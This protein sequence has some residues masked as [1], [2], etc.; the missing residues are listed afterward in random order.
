[1]IFTVMT[2]ENMS[3][4]F[5]YWLLRFIKFQ[6]IKNID[7]R[8]VNYFNEL[9][10]E[11]KLFKKNNSRIK[12]NFDIRKAI[13]ISLNNLQV[14]KIKNVY[15]I[16]IPDNIMFPNYDVSISTACKLFNYGNSE[17]LGFPLYTK[18][19]NNI[20]NNIDNYYKLYLKQTLRR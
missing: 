10:N 15:I 19:F 4:R 3:N 17:I 7:N 14:H 6:L 9:V 8:K 18:I 2:N 1:M 13:L 20:N 12:E 16:R 5:I 11:Q